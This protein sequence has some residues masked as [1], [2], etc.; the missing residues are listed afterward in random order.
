MSRYIF[1]L[2]YVAT[3]AAFSIG[4]FFSN[5]SFILIS[6]Y[7]YL[8]RYFFLGCYH[9]QLKTFLFQSACRQLFSGEDKISLSYTR[10]FKTGTKYDTSFF[11]LLICAVHLHI[12]LLR[13]KKSRWISQKALYHKARK[14][15]T[16]PDASENWKDVE[17]WR[18]LVST[19]ETTLRH[20]Y[21]TTTRSR[22]RAGTFSWLPN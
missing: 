6:T 1:F 15:Q 8:Q 2:F 18:H 9:M 19:G 17:M 4:V 22:D 5:W 7:A 3:F 11:F 10:I 13:K 14:P 20:P 21:T 16:R 12:T